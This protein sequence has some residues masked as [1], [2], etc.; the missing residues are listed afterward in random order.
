MATTGVAISA[1]RVAGE[2]SDVS[3]WLFV[4][5]FS[6]LLFGADL[7]R[8][9]EEAAVELARTSNQPLAPT[10]IDV[11]ATSNPWRTVLVGVVGLLIIAVGMIMALG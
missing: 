10:R 3:S 9:V 11:F 7:L 5:G 1:S 6:L 8:S 4:A 2:S